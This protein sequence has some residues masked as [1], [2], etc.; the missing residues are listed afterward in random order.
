[1]AG[2]WSGL[3]ATGR[4]ISSCR[5]K[6]QPKRKEIRDQP[7][8]ATSSE[9]R[10]STEPLEDAPRPH[11]VMSGRVESGRGNRSKEGGVKRSISGEDRVWNR[12][13]Q[14][15]EEQAKQVLSYRS[16][17]MKTASSRPP[18]DAS[19]G[20]FA[21]SFCQN[22]LSKQPNNN[23]LQQRD[24]SSNGA[25]GTDPTLLQR[26]SIDGNTQQLVEEKSK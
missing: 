10:I 4:P 22:F 11:S 7:I 17:L 1:M 6:R 18:E 21:A 2:D 12:I 5:T 15:Q 20:T 24:V 19:R 16:D 13:S 25:D 9:I 8:P 3:T 14:K 23:P 26:G